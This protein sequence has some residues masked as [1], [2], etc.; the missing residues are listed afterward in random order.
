M[1]WVS[2]YLHILEKLG[3]LER[4]GR[5]YALL[6]GALPRAVRLLLNLE[7]LDLPTSDMEP[8]D[9]PKASKA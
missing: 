4:D 7:K 5:R 1:V 2:R 8:F 9:G 6:D 3:L